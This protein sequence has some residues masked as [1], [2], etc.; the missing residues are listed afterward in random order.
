MDQ[1][2]SDMVYRGR[3]NNT[4]REWNE[5]DGK[6]NAGGTIIASDGTSYK[7]VGNRLVQILDPK[8]K[9]CVDRISAKLASDGLVAMNNNATKVSVTADAELV[10]E[11]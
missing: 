6:N 4:V 2:I 10:A 5:Q 3:I 1:T 7:K 8:M 9:K 11:L